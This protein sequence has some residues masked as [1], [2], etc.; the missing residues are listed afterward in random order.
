MAAA[1]LVV[2]VAGSLAF[3][4]RSS[5]ASNSGL[6]PSAKTNEATPAPAAAT[7][8]RVPATTHEVVEAGTVLQNRARSDSAPARTA[9]PPARTRAAESERRA[10]PEPAPAPQLVLPKGK[11]P[12]VSVAIAGAPTELK[13]VSPEMLV[14]ARTRL[15]SGQDA[16]DQ[17]DY[18][19]AR[20]TFHGALQ[21]LDSLASRYPASEKIRDLHR[22]IEQADANALQACNAENEMRKRRGIQG[23]AC[24]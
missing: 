7:T 3:L 17:G 5:S 12:N 1:A 9:S 6:Q 13:M 15:S 10:A 21:Q 14:D 4:A 16:V 20:R 19:M 23:K 24:Q 18:I 2:A 8:S 11:M 22:E